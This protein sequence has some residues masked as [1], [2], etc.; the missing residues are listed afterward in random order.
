MIQLNPGQQIE[1]IYKL[2]DPTDTGTYYVRA[3][4]KN[5]LTHATIE[6]INLTDRGGQLFSKTWDVLQDSSANGLQIYIIFSAYTDSGYTTKSPNY[7]EIVEQYVIYQRWGLQFGG[8][9]GSGVSY[10]KIKEIIQEELKNIPQSE[11]AKEYDLVGLEKRVVRAVTQEISTIEIPPQQRVDLEPI[12]KQIALLF[13]EIRD[14]PTPERIDYERFITSFSQAIGV[15][16]EKIVADI[17]AF[18]EHFNRNTTESKEEL[19]DFIVR[20]VFQALSGQI[21]E[22]FSTMEQYLNPPKELRGLDRK[23]DF[24]LKR[25]DSRRKQIV[26]KYA[27]GKV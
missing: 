22:R 7:Q 9:G 17:G 8:G 26:Q 4:V 20:A 16:V 19:R 3:V 10:Q 2:T 21:D 24:T 6:S 27:N 15:A 13:R 18:T 23:L 12:A 1:L 11:P 5:A 25:L 14:I